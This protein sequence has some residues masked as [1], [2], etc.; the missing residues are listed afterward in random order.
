MVNQ[1]CWPGERRGRHRARGMGSRLWRTSADAVGLFFVVA[2]HS[3]LRL[4]LLWKRTHS[5]LIVFLIFKSQPQFLQNNHPFGN[6]KENKIKLVFFWFFF[7]LAPHPLFRLQMLMLENQPLHV[8]LHSLITSGYSKSF[9]IIQR[10]SSRWTRVILTMLR[11]CMCL[12][13]NW[14]TPFPR[15]VSLMIR[16]MMILCNWIR[17]IVDWEQGRNGIEMS[18]NAL[19]SSC[20]LVMLHEMM[21]TDIALAERNHEWG[22]LLYLTLLYGCTAVPLLPCDGI[23]FSMINR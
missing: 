14:T 13:S 1:L 3:K 18:I 5:S 23:P 12:R 21:I 19:L 20:F 10:G 4:S 17:T 22:R 7:F 8:S 2:W 9:T 15:E 11:C 16:I 6:G